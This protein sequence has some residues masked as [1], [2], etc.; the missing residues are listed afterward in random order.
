MG[1]LRSLVLPEDIKQ[2]L[3][4]IIGLCGKVSVAKVNLSPSSTALI[5]LILR[6]TPPKQKE[7]SQLAGLCSVISYRI[8]DCSLVSQQPDHEKI[9]RPV[10][11]PTSIH[12][13]LT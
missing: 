1:S 10:H 12:L 2:L 8:S 5:T 13:P 11:S 6:S 7:T 9:K 4:Q 3:D